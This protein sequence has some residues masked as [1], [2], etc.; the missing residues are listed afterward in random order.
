MDS[1]LYAG[2][3]TFLGK[4]SRPDPFQPDR[5][6]ANML[7]LRALERLRETPFSGMTTVL[8]P[9]SIVCQNARHSRS[10]DPSQSLMS[11]ATS[12][13]LASIIGT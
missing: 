8:M 12:S 5:Q 11:A 4:S 9:H 7:A 6:P 1:R 3:Q 10:K 13:E 2:M